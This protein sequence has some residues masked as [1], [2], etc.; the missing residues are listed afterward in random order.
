MMNKLKIVCQ[1]LCSIFLKIL[2][3]GYVHI[4]SLFYMEILFLKTYWVPDF[5]YWE[6]MLRSGLLDH[7]VILCFSVWGAATPLPSGAAPLHRDWNRSPCTKVPV[8]TIHKVQNEEAAQSFMERWMDRQNVWPSTQYYSNL[9][10]NKILKYPAI[11][12]W[13]NHYAK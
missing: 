13:S 2:F 11:W 5:S 6:Y 3:Y 1:K 9:K 8:S 4:L 10:M 7:M 12:M